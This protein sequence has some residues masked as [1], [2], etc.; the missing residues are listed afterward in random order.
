LKQYRNAPILLHTFFSADLSLSLS[1]SSHKRT[2]AVALVCLLCVSVY[3]T[4]VV[5]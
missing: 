2:S 1:I 5:V 3:W 4:I